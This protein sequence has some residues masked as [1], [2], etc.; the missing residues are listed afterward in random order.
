MSLVIKIT[1]HSS[2]V[3]TV[4]TLMFRSCLQHIAIE[5]WTA[6]GKCVSG[7]VPKWRPWWRPWCCASTTCPC[8]KSLLTRPDFKGFR[9]KIEENGLGNPSNTLPFTPTWVFPTHSDAIDGKKRC[10]SSCLIFL[11]PWMIKPHR[12]PHESWDLVPRSDKLSPVTKMGQKS[13]HFLEKP[14]G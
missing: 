14:I 2:K 11:G 10:V 9:W 6:E 5:P 12:D 13:H 8:F 1:W 4:T 3:V 7:V